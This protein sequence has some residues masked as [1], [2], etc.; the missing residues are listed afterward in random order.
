MK[1]GRFAGYPEPGYFRLR[2]VKRGPWVPALIW[3][4][5]PMVIPVPLELTP[6][7]ED[8]CRPAERSRPLRATIGTS[9]ANPFEVWISGYFIT[10]QEYLYR[11]DLQKWATRHA[12]RQPEAK[13]KQSVDLTD[14]PALF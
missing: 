5:C 4:P 6:A 2:L 3:Q 8:W 7:P 13:P 14:L 11:L 1:Q 9:E 12:P 10:A